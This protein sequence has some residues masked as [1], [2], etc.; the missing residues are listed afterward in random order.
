MRLGIKRIGAIALTLVIALLLFPAPVAKG[1]TEEDVSEAE[2]LRINPSAIGEKRETWTSLTDLFGVNILT[3]DSAQIRAHAAEALAANRADR[4]DALFAVDKTI[5]IDPAEA[6]EQ[7]SLAHNLFQRAKEE[8]YF[9]PASTGLLSSDT[10]LYAVG[11]TVIAILGVGSFFA[12]LAWN[13]R[14]NTGR[15][16]E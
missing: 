15:E 3:D 10:L 12:A 2:M 14:K 8:A 5:V 1:S 13:R 11:G 4:K 7:A 9:Q 16:G 6:V